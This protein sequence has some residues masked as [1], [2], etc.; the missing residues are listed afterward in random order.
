MYGIIV[1][2]KENAKHNK[3]YINWYIEKFSKRNVNLS[4]VYAD[5]I[6]YSK[7]YDFAI[8][9]AMRCDITKK[10]EDKGVRCFNNYK[11][12]YITND[13]GKCYDYMV[14]NNIEIL[15]TC[16]KIEDIKKYPVVV[17]PKDSH[18]GDRVNLAKNSEELEKLMPLYE[19]DNY[20][21][22]EVAQDLGKDLRVYVLG[23]KIVASMLRKSNNLRS[24]FCL[25]GSADI[26]NLSNEEKALVNKIIS[27]FDFDFVGIDFLFNNGKIIF[28]EIEDVVGSR[29]LY[30]Y[31]DIDI[32]EE[33]VKYILSKLKK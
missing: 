16:Y 11:V 8:V 20:I 25:G 3:N 7:K 22:Q 9:R 6:D 26:Y 13:K 14:K 15:K 12:S 27:L 24:N 17:K 32:V 5:E 30:T 2:E 28:N 10:L 23:G 33:Y 4:L 31:T 19:K 18:G 1:Y 21:F 29:M